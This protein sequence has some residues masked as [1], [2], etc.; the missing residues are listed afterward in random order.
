[1][2]V[3]RPLSFQGLLASFVLLLFVPGL[4][5]GDYS[6]ILSKLL[7]T[8]ILASSLY[9]VAADRKDLVI[10]VCL[11]LPTLLSNWLPVEFESDFYRLF[12]YAAFQTV[13]LAY[14]SFI[15]W[16]CLGRDIFRSRVDRPECNWIG[17]INRQGHRC[18]R[19]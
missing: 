7:F 1:M 3:I 2:R 19:R 4:F 12:F 13:F 16:P 18:K 5:Y 11:A 15:S 8:V 10:G 17:S 6:A 14:I 9:A